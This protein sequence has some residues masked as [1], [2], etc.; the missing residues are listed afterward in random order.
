MRSIQNMESSRDDKKRALS[1]VALKKKDLREERLLLA[2]FLPRPPLRGLDRKRERLHEAISNLAEDTYGTKEGPEVY[3][4]MLHE[5]SNENE[6]LEGS[7]EKNAA[8]IEYNFLA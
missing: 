3:R 1:C 6:D 7:Q 4:E 2:F 8:T 5:I